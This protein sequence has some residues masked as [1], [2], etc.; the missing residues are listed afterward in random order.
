MRRILI[1]IAAAMIAAGVSQAQTASQFRI[2][3][4]PGHGSYTAND[5][6]CN[7]IGHP[8]TTTLAD[9]LGFFEGRSNLA[10]SFYIG[11]TLQQMGVKSSNIVYS[12]TTNGPWPDN[13]AE[14]TKYNR[15]LS[16]IC[17]EVEAGHFDMFLSSHS[18]A[19]GTDG[20]TANY[21]TYLYRGQDTRAEVPGSREMAVTN[22]PW[23]HMTELEPQSAFN[24]TMNIRG[25]WD[26]YGSY[27]TSTR[28]NGKS[29][30]GYLGV[31]K[32]GTPGYLLE[33]F[34]H[35]YQPARHRALNFDYDRHEGL[36]EA[37]GICAYFGFQQL[38]TGAILGTVKDSKQ[39]IHHS[40]YHY[41]PGTDDQYVPLNGA[42]V[43]LMQNGKVV[44]TYTVDN[45]W[46]GIYSFFDLAP[47]TYQLKASCENYK[48][49]EPVTVTVK[50]NETIYPLLHLDGDGT[51]PD[52]P[53]EAVKGIY[54]YKL[55]VAKGSNDD[56]IF[57]FDAN[58]NAVQANIAFY[59]AAT[60]GEVGTIPV[61]NVKEGAN[62]VTVKD[63]DLPGNVGSSLNWAVTLQ[64]KPI[65]DFQ[66][67]N[68][69]S[70]WSFTRAFNTVDKNPESPFF[71]NIYV[72]DRPDKNS[73]GNG[74]YAYSPDW[75]RINSNVI[76][77]RDDG[78]T[79]NSN[80]R[81]GI[82]GDG[83]VYVPDWG[84]ATSGVF[85]LDP[86]HLNDGFKTFFR[87][88]NGTQLSRNSDGLLSNP[89]GVAVASSSPSVYIKGYGT[90]TRM[91]VYNEDFGNIVCR[92]DIGNADG[93]V[94]PYWDKAPSFRYPISYLQANTNGNVVADSEGNIWVAQNRYTD[95]NTPSVPSLIYVD[96]DGNV[97][98]NSGNDPHLA[99]NY[100]TGSSGS[101]FAV[102]SDGKTLVI[103]D[104]Y[105]YLK[106][107]DITWNGKT[108]K[109]TYRQEFY[110]DAVDGS[111]CIYEMTFDYAG[112]L[113]ASGSNVGIYSI[114][115]ENNCNTTPARKA[116][117]VTK[118][119]SKTLTDVTGD[120]K[121]DIV[122]VN[123]IINII[124]GQEAASKYSNRSDV[125]GDGKTD[126]VD[127]NMVINTILGL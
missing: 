127:L 36:R 18:D 9:T 122:D 79:F 41:A 16:E 76:S 20:T 6:P 107:F 111:N 56:Y 87:N 2:Y 55:N 109:L 24:S 75:K 81:I 29:Y 113:I 125:G 70:G 8:N 74:I 50:A 85:V 73:T 14:S 120:G 100:L 101:G 46:N 80:Y 104:Y 71:G 89:S 60:G 42:V 49:M 53:G 64:G 97:L 35:T 65:K 82:D 10:R 62:T 19:T 61:P 47:G 83:K 92:Y 3:L 25:D 88:A 44:K 112:N 7:T 39:I 63:I 116:L 126:V 67:L 118:T 69:K 114:P 37:R 106:F 45:E 93:S 84:D 5:R 1:I 72:G 117:T 28:S 57:T 115:T 23:H 34:F 51:G 110:C 31:L 58:S 11:H 121:T 124:L 52:V 86:A 102:S 103:N 119:K 17:E 95:Q 94:K 98:Y 99:Q 108:P 43:E 59:D 12:R 21:P 48:D 13:P 15:N 4:N 54:A 68:T 96:K 32:H 27:S 90:D 78:L 66:R 38:T 40:L 33:G 30:T 91:Y 105:G 123:A 77:K 26:F 22:W